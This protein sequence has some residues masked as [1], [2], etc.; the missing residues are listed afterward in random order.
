M[1]RYFFHSRDGVSHH[2]RTGSD[3]PDLDAA[4]VEAVRYMSELLRDDSAEVWRT[5]KLE[6]AIVDMGGAE[7]CV[8]T[9]AKRE[10]GADG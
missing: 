1:P 5:G 9:V 2:D 8:L 6:L 4:G 10:A 7:L 3:L